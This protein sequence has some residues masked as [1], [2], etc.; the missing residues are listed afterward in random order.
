[1]FLLNQ[2]NSVMKVLLC[3]SYSCFRLSVLLPLL[4]LIP[5]PA[6]SYWLITFP[7]L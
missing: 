5:F 2:L 6:P 7:D 3:L 4:V 1:M